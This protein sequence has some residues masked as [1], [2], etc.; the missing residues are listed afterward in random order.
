MKRRSK[1]K[2]VDR[3]ASR[4]LRLESLEH[5]R[6]LAAVP[7]G[8]TLQDTGEF[9]LG[10]VAV[11]PVL[12]ESNGA[13][14]QESQDWVSAEI[15]AAMQGNICRC[16]MYGRIRKAI[17]SVD[18]AASSEGKLFYNVAGVDHG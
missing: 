9:L 5:R 6:L 16:G 15:D 8:A 18:I 13:T 3:P 14:D 12:F 10:S 2:R 1:S 11:T 7:M 17:K 4:K